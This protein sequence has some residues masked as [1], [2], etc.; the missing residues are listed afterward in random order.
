[1]SY[2]RSSDEIF[3]EGAIKTVAE[4]GIENLR[5]KHIADYADF[6]EATMYRRFPSKE[7]ILREA[8]LYVDKR[9]SNILTQSAFIR[10]PEDKPFESAAY[11]VW[12]KIYRYLIEHEEE[13]VF[14]I[15][16]RYSSYYTDEVR[17][18]RQAYNGSF[19]RVYAVFDKYFGC[20]DHSRREYLFNY[21]FEMTLCFTEKVVTGKMEDNRES[22]QGVWTAVSSVAKTWALQQRG[23]VS[24]EQ[25]AEMAQQTGSAGAVSS[26]AAEE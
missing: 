20:T 17:A 24:E 5:T 8:F 14:L 3:I 21:I 4:I 19:D 11:A 15:R 7:A 1:M 12:H 2:R 22:E 23:D 25:R 6:T 9:I 18:M 16:Y 26:P 13:T 10:K